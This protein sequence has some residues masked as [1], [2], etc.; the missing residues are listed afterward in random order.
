MARGGRRRERLSFASSRLEKP[1]LDSL[2]R[3]PDV[4]EEGERRR[5]LDETVKPLCVESV[6]LLAPLPPLPE[7]LNE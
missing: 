7:D 4:P 6:S 1:F 3:D 2:P 5:E